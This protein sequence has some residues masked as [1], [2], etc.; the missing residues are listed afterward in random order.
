MSSEQELPDEIVLSHRQSKNGKISI[1][2]LNRP[3][4]Y[5]A[6]TGEHYR[7]LASLMHEIDSD[8]ECIATLW[9]GTGQYFR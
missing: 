9:I 8:D 5:N 1:I 7:H 2:T 4:K 6:L 3:K